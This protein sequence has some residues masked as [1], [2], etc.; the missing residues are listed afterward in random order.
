MMPMMMLTSL[1]A[2]FSLSLIPD[3]ILWQENLS[4]L[5]ALTGAPFPDDVLTF[6]IPVC[7]PY[8]AMSAFKFKVKL[9]PGTGKRGKGK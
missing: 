5:D 8:S 2:V 9:I 1:F 3:L 4:Y 6:A 7:A